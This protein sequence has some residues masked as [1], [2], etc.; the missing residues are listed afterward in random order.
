VR[1]IFG[2]GNP[3]TRYQNNRHNTGFALL[4]YI[5]RKNSLSFIASKSSYYYCKGIINNS[6]YL[7]VKPATYVNNSG[8]AALELVEN[9]NIE[10][11][12]LLVVHDDLGLDVGRI[13]I[14]IS[15]G[16]GGH[17]GV[18][19]IIYHLRSDEFP[20]IRIGIGN[21]FASGDMSAYVLSDFNPEEIKIIH[22]SFETVHLLINEFIL[23]GLR[24]ILDTNSKIL[25]QNQ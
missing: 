1:V 4:D 24:R 20:R 7:L 19:S 10:I 12:D 21:N 13:K 8:I 6:A 23:G 16:D 5:A 2:I 9:L 22:N 17:N 14:K 11:P 25:R 15:G 18:G 3:G